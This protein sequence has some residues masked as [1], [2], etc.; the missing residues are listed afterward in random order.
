MLTYLEGARYKLQSALLELDH[1]PRGNHPLAPH[2]QI[3][4]DRTGLQQTIL[5]VPLWLG[6]GDDTDG[7]SERYCQPDLNAN[8]TDDLAESIYP[9]AQNENLIKHFDRNFNRSQSQMGDIS[10]SI[11]TVSIVD[12]P[13]IAVEGSKHF[14]RRSRSPNFDRGI[15]DGGS[16]QPDSDFGR[17]LTYLTLD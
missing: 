15:A 4:R 10:P 12:H 5:K 11:G 6:N 7:L 16:N 9:E 17:I 1:K 8:T 3:T 2:V 13:K 14:E